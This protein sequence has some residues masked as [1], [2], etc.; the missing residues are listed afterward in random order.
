MQPQDRLNASAGVALV[1]AGQIPHQ[2]LVP[3][4]AEYRHVASMHFIPVQNAAQRVIQVR[5][6]ARL[7]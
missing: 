7:I 4:R 1:A 3:E 2:G 6:S 5:V